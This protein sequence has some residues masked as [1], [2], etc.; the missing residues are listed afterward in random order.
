MDLHF[1]QKSKME[2]ANTKTVVF[3]S[4]A[5]DENGNM[6]TTYYGFIEEMWELDY[7]Q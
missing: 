5:H 3:V 4:N 2:R 6:Q 7:G 1:T